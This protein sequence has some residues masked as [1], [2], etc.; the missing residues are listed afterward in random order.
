MIEMRRV[1]FSFSDGLIA[2]EVSDLRDQ[3]MEAADQVLGDEEIVT[4]VCATLVPI[5]R[6]DRRMGTPAE[7]VCAYWSSS[8]CAT[9]PDSPRC[10]PMHPRQ[11]ASS[12]HAGISLTHLQAFRP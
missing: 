8:T 9:G 4:A 5:T 3:R 12:E 7:V 6:A 2:P 11:A 10:C 1:Q